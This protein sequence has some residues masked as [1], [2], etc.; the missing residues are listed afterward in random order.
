MGKVSNA[1]GQIEAEDGKRKM[2]L[3]HLFSNWR[4]TGP[5]EPVTNLVSA[6]H[7]AG[8]D[9]T[10]SFGQQ[11]RAVKNGIV[12]NAQERG[13]PIRSGLLL[14]KH[15]NL[16][17]DYSDS[18]R[19]RKWLRNDHFNIVHAH[20]RNAHVIAALSIRPI[21]E[22]PL[23]VRTCY[24]GDGPVGLREAVLLR[25]YTDGLIVVSDRARRTVIDKVGFQADRIW[26]VHTPIDMDR[27]N[28][29]RGLGDRREEFGIDPDAFVVGIIARIQWRRRFHVFLEAIDRA[30]HKLPNLRAIIVGR[31]TNMK[32][33]AL[34]PIKRMKLNDIIVIPGYQ[35]GD[36]F[37]RT[38]A[39][40]DV[41][42]FL[43]P[44]T[45]G[46]CRAVREAMAMVVPIIASQ[47]GM[48]PE[49]VGDGERGL[50]IDDTPENLANAITELAHDRER[51]IAFGQH[52][53]QFARNHF[54]LDRQADIVGSIY[55]ELMERS[56]R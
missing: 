47:R 2:K 15:S 30:R 42:V 45:D 9:V 56:K 21:A 39:S 36:D 23:I 54:S 19:L 8:W 24:A 43:V 33:I 44:G 46:S 17:Y 35:T 4:W 31:G 5:A 37:V 14:Q 13:L 27:F 6:L 55:R 12:Q 48:L 51:R 18:R 11:R 38:I 41:N 29:D 53:R 50:I 16:L 25:R 22:K 10:F 49:L 7:R 52:A 20:L 32:P 28:P 26:S 1:K 3:L 34:D 40:M